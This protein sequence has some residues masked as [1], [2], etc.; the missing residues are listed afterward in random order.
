MSTLASHLSIF[1]SEKTVIPIKPGQS[2]T[3]VHH[4]RLWKQFHLYRFG[5]CLLFPLDGMVRDMIRSLT[6]E[7]TY[8]L[9]TS[10]RFWQARAWPDWNLRKNA[11]GV[12]S[13]E[14]TVSVRYLAPAQTRTPAGTC[15]DSVPVSPVGVLFKSIPALSYFSQPDWSSS[16]SYIYSI[17]PG[18]LARLA[19]R[20][21]PGKWITPTG[22]R[23]ISFSVSG[24]LGLLE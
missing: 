4:C 13:L 23:G 18:P 9:R 3:L 8:I 21:R 17:I 20:G 11:S 15:M 24:S 14:F 7:L 12:P 22:Q 5:E 6:Q 2:V 16:G 1:S 10:F 19:L